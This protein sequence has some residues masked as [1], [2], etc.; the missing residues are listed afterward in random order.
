MNTSGIATQTHREAHSLMLSGDVWHDR[1]P[2]E[3]SA[4]MLEPPQSFDTGSYTPVLATCDIRP[5]KEPL[6]NI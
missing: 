5:P 2:P 4:G 3:T 1:H 6:E